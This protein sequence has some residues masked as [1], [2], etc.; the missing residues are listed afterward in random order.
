MGSSNFYNSG[1]ESIIIPDNIKKIQ[2]ADFSHCENLKYIDLN[3]VT[4]L[5]ILS[6]AYCTSLES[7]DLTN[8][9]YYEKAQ[10]TALLSDAII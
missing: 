8:V 1:I 5:S 10:E 6:F 7:I 2:Q 3:N 9:T 4:S